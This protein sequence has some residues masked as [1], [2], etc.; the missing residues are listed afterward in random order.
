[1]S[2]SRRLLLGLPLALPFGLRPARAA[3]AGPAVIERFYGELLAVMKEG[4]RLSFDQRYSRLAP[5]IA[6]TFDLALMTRIAIGPGWAQLAADQ[7]QRLTDAFTRFTISNYA[8]RF[9]DY[10]GER[11]EVSPATTAN[12]NGTI[13]NSRIIKANGEPVTLKYLMQQEGGGW[14][15]LDVYLSGTVSELATRRSEFASVL[16]RNGAEGLVRL[17]EQKS[18]ALRAG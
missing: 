18:A 3:D 7:Q 16:Q 11:F 14:K 4:K 12:A 2:F 13:V 8:S 1:M 15:A 17:I 9:D 5:T 10:G 6:Q